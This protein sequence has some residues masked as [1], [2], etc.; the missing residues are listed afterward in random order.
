VQELTSRDVALKT[1]EDAISPQVEPDVRH[2]HKGNRRSRRVGIRKLDVGEIG[3]ISRHTRDRYLT[4][5]QCS[6][7]GVFLRSE[8]RGLLLVK[9]KVVIWGSL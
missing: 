8:A 5:Q 2:G 3:R 6:V 1:P 9:I 7:S 4:C